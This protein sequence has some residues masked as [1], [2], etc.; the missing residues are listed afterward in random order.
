ML[1]AACAVPGLACAQS[2]PARQLPA[3]GT[4]EFAFTPE[5]DATGAIRH[6]I[7]AARRSIHVQ[8]YSFTSNEIAFALIEA[9]RRG[10][11][12]QVI[13]DGEQA[14][15]LEYSRIPLLAEAGVPVWLDEQHQSAHNKVMLIDALEARPTVITG[16]MNFTYAG[17]FKNADNVLL[18]HDNAPLARA[19]L[20]NWKRHFE[21][22]TPYPAPQGSMLES[23]GP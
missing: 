5:Q 18:L 11:D 7:R 21:H 14:R 15:K 19:Y 1:L 8:A 10:V 20:E 4:I 9:K 17:Q 12:V 22:A 6:A 16:S 2:S 13:A 23:P 3:T